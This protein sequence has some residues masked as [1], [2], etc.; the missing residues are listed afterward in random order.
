[1]FV[2]GRHNAKGYTLRSRSAKIV[3]RRKTEQ[4]CCS[5]SLLFSPAF[6]PTVFILFRTKWCCFFLLLLFAVILAVFVWPWQSVF[7]YHDAIVCVFS[8]CKHNNLVLT[9]CRV[10]FLACVNFFAVFQ[11][12]PCLAV[13]LC[14]FLLCCFGRFL[15]SFARFVY[16]VL[17]PFNLKVMRYHCA[18]LLRCYCRFCCLLGP[19]GGVAFLLLFPLRCHACTAMPPLCPSVPRLPHSSFPSVPKNLHATSQTMCV[20]LHPLWA[21]THGYVCARVCSCF[22]AVVARTVCALMLVFALAGVSVRVFCVCLCVCG[23]PVCLSMCLH[24]HFAFVCV[25]VCLHFAKNM[26][27]SITCIS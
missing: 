14:C 16:L 23:C 3:W 9:F 4:V 22:C 2:A 26:C 5:R 20:H 25:S 6:F 27:I 13:L 12:F 18:F 11:L 8:G 24:M 21:R 17:L 10:C 7:V 1:M 15:A 19:A